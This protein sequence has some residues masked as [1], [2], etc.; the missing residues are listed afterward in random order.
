M[1]EQTMVAAFLHQVAAHA[2]AKLPATL[3]ERLG[4]ARALVEQGAVVLDEAGRYSV[5]SEE[6]PPRLWP[7]NG[8]CICPDATYRAPEG[9]C[10]HRLA[11][12]LHKRV[13]TLLPPV[14]ASP[15]PPLAPTPPLPEAPASMNVH[16]TI[17]GR[18]VQLTLRDTDE[19]RLLARLDAVLQRFPVPEPPTETPRPPK[20]WCA[21]HSVQMQENHKDGRTW[22][23]H[24]TANGWCKGKG[25][26]A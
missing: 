10:K 17:H 11:A 15:E 23:S 18:H 16:L 13:H 8:V 14:E 25:S 7:V 1:I 19:G 26:A 24:R 6:D 2:A 3:H 5:R 12:A 9:W 20:G 4:T 22:Y 21:R